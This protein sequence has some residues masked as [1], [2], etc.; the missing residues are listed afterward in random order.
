MY[1][2]PNNEEK[3]SEDKVDSG[4]GAEGG[5]LAWS[6]FLAHIDCPANTQCYIRPVAVDVIYILFK[7]SMER[8]TYIEGLEKK[9]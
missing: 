7:S 2:L 9:L 6:S 3:K 8:A 4:G 5:V 1:L